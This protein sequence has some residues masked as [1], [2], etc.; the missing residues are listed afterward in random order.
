[1]GH[2][3]GRGLRSGERESTQKGVVVQRNRT[4]LHQVYKVKSQ[5]RKVFSHFTL[6]G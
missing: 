4:R 5:R 3:I 6:H 2:G 1:M